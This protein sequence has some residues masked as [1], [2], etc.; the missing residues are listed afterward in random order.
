MSSLYCIKKDE[1]LN[2][3]RVVFQLG[4]FKAKN[5]WQMDPNKIKLTFEYDIFWK[6]LIRSLF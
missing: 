1:G 2:V 4:V 5:L 3:E 6:F